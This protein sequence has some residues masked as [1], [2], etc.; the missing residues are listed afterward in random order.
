MVLVRSICF[1]EREHQVAR[2]IAQGKQ[3][4]E[5]AYE[6]GIKLSTARNYVADIFDKLNVADRTSIA[7]YMLTGYLPRRA[8]RE[9][10]LDEDQD[11]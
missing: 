2:L 4:K 6:L 10:Q 9:E 1:S 11:Q 7:V 8:L 5:I 3:N